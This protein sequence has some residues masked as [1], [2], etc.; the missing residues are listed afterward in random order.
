VGDPRAAAAHRRPVLGRDPAKKGPLRAR[1]DTDTTL[2][3]L[4]LYM[5]PGAYHQLA[6]GAAGPG[7]AI[8]AGS[9]RRSSGCCW[10]M[11]RPHRA[12]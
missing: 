2:D 4:L 12:A 11:A 5:A 3:L 9:P 6:H 7:S 1:F 8:S 10:T